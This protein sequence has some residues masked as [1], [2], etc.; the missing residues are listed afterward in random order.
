MVDQESG[1]QRALAWELVEEG[2]DK[3]ARYRPF[4]I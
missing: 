2:Q 4:M 3:E 1:A